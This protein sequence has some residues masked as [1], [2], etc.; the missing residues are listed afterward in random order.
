MSEEFFKYPK[1]LMASEDFTPIEKM[2]WVVLE[3]RHRFFKGQG[4]PHHD[5][6][7]YVEASTG[8]SKTKVQEVL[9]KLIEMGIVKAHKVG[10]GYDGRPLVKSGGVT[11]NPVRK[12]VFDNVAPVIQN[13][14]SPTAQPKPTPQAKPV[15][16]VAPA[17]PPQKEYDVYEDLEYDPPF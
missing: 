3:D 11:N 2:V 16:P 10:I 7:K 12:W 5:T 17:M 1:W 13:W 8:A 14:R 15:V 4:M 9:K 6:L